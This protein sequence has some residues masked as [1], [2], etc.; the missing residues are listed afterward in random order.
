MVC[1]LAWA[2]PHVLSTEPLYKFLM[3]QLQRRFSVLQLGFTILVCQDNSSH[4]LSVYHVVDMSSAPTPSREPV[5]Y[6]RLL[7]PFHRQGNKGPERLRLRA[8]E[9][10]EVL[11]IS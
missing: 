5:G 9:R 10:N 7:Y 11:A 8:L 6:A 1:D 4:L 3:V 2:L